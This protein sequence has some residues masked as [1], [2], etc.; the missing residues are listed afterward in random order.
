MSKIDGPLWRYFG[1]KWRAGGRYPAPVHSTIVEPFAGAAN[2]ALRHADRNVV[3][4]EKSPIIV[5]IWSW[6]IASPPTDILAVPTTD[7]VDDLPSWVSQ[8]ARWLVG[9]WM[10]SAN[11]V[12][13]RNLS[14]GE[15]RMRATGRKF[16]GWCD[17]VRDRA[18][19][20][21]AAVKHWRVIEGSYDSAPDVE[22]T[23]FID[24]PYQ[25]A[26]SFYPHGSKGIDYTVL[27]SWC[28]ARRGQTLVCEGPG[29][30][31][32][33]FR[34]MNGHDKGQMG[35]LIEER[36]WTGEELAA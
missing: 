6:I 10:N 17:V 5:G 33:P 9:F 11:T 28:R 27:G 26:G 14:A 7:S 35:R 4:V 2:Y 21:A 22:A 25:H 18:A 30:E 1:G 19:R 12:P 13:C 34:V 29:A 24:P 31:W 23:W 15:R 3:L 8:E 20:I 32:L 36:L 16:I